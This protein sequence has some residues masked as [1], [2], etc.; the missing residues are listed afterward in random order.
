MGVVL[1]AQVLKHKLLEMYAT[2]MEYILVQYKLLIVELVIAVFK[3]VNSLH[4][5]SV[6]HHLRQTA[7]L[8]T[9]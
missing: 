5:S 4:L 8:K 7:W 1:T 2:D 6:Q 9:R 3:S